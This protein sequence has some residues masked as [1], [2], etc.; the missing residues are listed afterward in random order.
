MGKASVRV[1]FDFR[2]PVIISFPIESV[3]K[4][5][6]CIEE[7]HLKKV[8]QQIDH[9]DEPDPHVLRIF[10]LSI[11]EGSQTEKEFDSQKQVWK[12]KILKNQDYP[13]FLFATSQDQMAPFDRVKLN[14]DINQFEHEKDISFDHFT[15]DFLSNEQV[16]TP[17][18]QN[19][20][21]E[22]QGKCLKCASLYVLDWQRNTC[23]RCANNYINF[24][25]KCSD[26]AKKTTSTYLSNTT[27]KE[28]LI[29][30]FV[31]QDI[32]DSGFPYKVFTSLDEDEFADPVFYSSSPLL[33]LSSGSSQKVIIF[34]K[35]IDYQYSTSLPAV[36]YFWVN[37]IETDSSSE[38]VHIKNR[39]LEFSKQS[40]VTQTTL[41][42]SVS[43]NTIQINSLHNLVY[44]Y[45]NTFNDTSLREFHL[46]S[47]Q[48]QSKILEIAYSDLMLLIDQEA[49]KGD[50]LVPTNLNLRISDSFVFES[51][52]PFFYRLRRK[53]DLLSS[54]ISD[55]TFLNEGSTFRFIS[56]CGLNCLSCS[57]E[58]H[59]LKCKS[60]Y[61]FYQGE[62]YKCQDKCKECE[63]T[64]A[65]C[66]VC[67]NKG[68]VYSSS[69]RKLPAYRGATT[70]L[71]LIARL[72]WADFVTHVILD[73][74]SS[75]A[76]ALTLAVALSSSTLFWKI[77]CPAKWAVLCVFR[78]MSVLS[79]CRT[80]YW[81]TTNANFCVQKAHFS[82]RI[83]TAAE[84][85]PK[86]VQNAQTT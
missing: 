9:L 78:P 11:F 22:V 5:S 34:E 67:T 30:K 27:M 44:T 38:T 28:Y 40:V 73:S 53:P 57:S 33:R 46:S 23:S 21:F 60:Q 64:Q 62:C 43:S 84:A 75:E 14:K 65:N 25:A 26:Q 10:E 7:L 58:L 2:D 72:Q 85:V 55:Y 86:T 1:E 17:I 51:Y 68:K 3:I 39:F 52:S 24:L 47:T 82:R 83:R 59:C 19:C 45:K 42:D 4:D 79:A 81:K 31:I 70:C 50:V 29:R 37:R 77:V 49:H 54:G 74:S 66:T 80:I 76:S 13:E 48:N 18:I 35:T 63:D 15:V 6:D 20:V 32:L 16:K 56:K 8:R 69:N 71:F 61:F 41:Y 36:N 12:A